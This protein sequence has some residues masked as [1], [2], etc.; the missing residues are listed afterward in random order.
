MNHYDMNL[1]CLPKS[2]PGGVWAA[3]VGLLFTCLF[4]ASGAVIAVAP[5]AGG[6]GIQRALEGLPGGGEV[7]LQAGTYRVGQPIILRHDGQALRGAGPETVLYLVDQA[8]CPVVILGNPEDSPKGP[9]RG[10]QLLSLF[11]D[12]NRKNQTREL[13]RSLA[14]GAQINNNGVTVWYAGD[15]TVEHVVC[16][17]C[18]S[19]GMVSSAGTRRLTVRDFTAFDNQFDGL[20]CYLTEE[21]HFSQLVLHDN[22]SAGIS[23]DLDFNRN[24]I[25]GAVLR[26]NDLGIFMRQSQSNVF[27]AM[28]IEKSRNHGV[29]MAQSGFRTASGW[30]LFPGSECTGNNF[31]Q[32]AISGSG[33]MAFLVNNDSCT[34]NVISNGRFWDNAGGGLSQARTHPV[35]A[36]ALVEGNPPPAL[37]PA[38]PAADR[39]MHQA[40]PVKSEPTTL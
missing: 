26:A 33:G 23:L 8:N 27:D 4:S 35:S 20:A 10:L 7:V 29:F 14:C 28:T 16:C 18:R 30:R 3:S 34:N 25:E 1:D 9:T 21:S 17:R 32:L 22:L 13:W 2:R 31:D 11:I 12:G 6:E 36:P 40:G 19:G 37:N 5:A 15:A 39:S 38:L 24:V